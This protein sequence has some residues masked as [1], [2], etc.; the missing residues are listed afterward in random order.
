MDGFVRALPV[1]S[2]GNPTGPGMHLV[3]QD[4]ISAMV[5]GPDG[6]IYLVAQGGDWGTAGPNMVYRLVKP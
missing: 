4:G 5:A 1:D 2:S 3:H 6:Y